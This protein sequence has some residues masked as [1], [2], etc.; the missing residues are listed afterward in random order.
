MSW[1]WVCSVRFDLLKLA[2]KLTCERDWLVSKLFRPLSAISGQ[3]FSVKW[4]AWMYLT[5][6]VA[7]VGIFRQPGCVCVCV[8]VV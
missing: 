2:S 8:C 7:C 1:N 6:N 5:S 3:P 4:T